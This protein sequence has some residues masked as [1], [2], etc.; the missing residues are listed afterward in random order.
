MDYIPSKIVLTR[1]T[2]F[3]EALSRDL[4]KIAAVFDLDPRVMAAQ[5]LASAVKESVEILDAL[6]VD[7]PSETSS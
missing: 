5:L 2:G 1:K 3:T 4:G 7:H 6:T